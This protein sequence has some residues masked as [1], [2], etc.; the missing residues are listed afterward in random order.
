MDNFVFDCIMAACFHC[1][2]FLGSHFE[3][4]WQDS[5]VWLCACG[6]KL[7]SFSLGSKDAEELGSIEVEPNKCCC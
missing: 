2:T 7:F 3:L 5:S 6:T 4:L 1:A